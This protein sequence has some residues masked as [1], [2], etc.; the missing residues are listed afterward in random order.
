MAESYPKARRLGLRTES[1]L[2][3]LLVY[4]LER[5]KAHCLNRTAAVV[6]ELADGTRSIEAIAR[7]VAVRAGIG[8]DPDVVRFCLEQLRRQ[9]LLELPDAPRRASAVSRRALI[10]RLGSAAVVPVVLSVSFPRPS[11]AQSAGEVGPTGP[12]GPSGAAGV[13]GPTGPAGPTG[14]TGPTGPPGVI[15]QTGPTGP[16]GLIPFIA[17]NLVLGDLGPTGPTG[18]R[19]AIGATGPTGPMGPTG[20]KGPLGEPGPT[21]PTGPT[22]PVGDTGPAGSIGPTGPTGPIPVA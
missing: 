18:P 17:P 21:G 8:E 20:P 22:G 14:P 15:G 19:G 13:T 9:G 12:E 1:I 7:E 3:E 2:D 6:W 4:D 10:A 11:A 16:A 5:K